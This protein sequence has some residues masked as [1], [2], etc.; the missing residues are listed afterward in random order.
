MSQIISTRTKVRG[1]AL[2][3]V[4]VERIRPTNPP[5]ANAEARKIKYSPIV[6]V[7]AEDEFCYIVD[8]NHRFYSKLK[9]VSQSARTVAWI[10][11]EG[12]EK[13][14]TGNPLPRP[15][16][17]WKDGLISFQQLCSMAMLAWQSTMRKFIEEIPTRF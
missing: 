6:L 5:D 1:K 7:L 9:K 12:D 13:R 16:Q 2:S 14:L 4:P 17:D 8:G 11:E 3:L 15:L 10:I